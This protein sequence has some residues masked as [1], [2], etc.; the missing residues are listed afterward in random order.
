M[1]YI[2][3]LTPFAAFTR[4]LT[5]IYS[6]TLLTLFTHM[7]LSILG[8]SKYIHSIIQAEQ[9]ERLREQMMDASLFSLLWNGDVSE[10]AETQ[11]AEVISEETERKYLTLSWW[12][13]HVGWKD[14][15]E[16]VRRGV[17]EVFEGYCST[18]PRM[19]RMTDTSA[20]SP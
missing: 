19:T 7:Q 18:G 11:S 13:L 3:Y 12:I 6:M 15:G 17:E 14:V 9:E 1:R 16:R 8:R 2:T 10:E 4:T 5:I 20:A